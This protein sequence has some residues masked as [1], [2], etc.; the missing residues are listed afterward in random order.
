MTLAF[1]NAYKVADRPLP[2]LFSFDK[3]HIS[4]IFPPEV[5]SIGHRKEELGVV[6]ATKMINMLDGKKEESIFLSWVL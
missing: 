3:S 5:I 6:A 2:K 4:D 1:I